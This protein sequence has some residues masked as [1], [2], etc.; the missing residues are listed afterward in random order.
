MGKTQGG[1]GRRG[2]RQPGIVLASK[3][4]G[5]VTRYLSKDSFPE[6]LV[7][8]LNYVKLHPGDNGREERGVLFLHQSHRLVEPLVIDTT[9]SEVCNR[10]ILVN[11][12]QAYTE[13]INS[14][15][16]TKIKIH[17]TF[18][19]MVQCHEVEIVFI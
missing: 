3:G 4:H 7:L 11:K 9:H 13:T 1:S 5:N 12:A 14:C 17:V 18:S 19:V 15:K 8:I 16:T 6:L 2:K 10:L